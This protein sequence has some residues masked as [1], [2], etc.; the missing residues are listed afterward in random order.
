MVSQD[1]VVQVTAVHR[2]VVGAGLGADQV[3]R[4]LEAGETSLCPLPLECHLHALPDE[5][6]FGYTSAPGFVLDDPQERARQFERH[7]CHAIRVP[8]AATASNTELERRG[9]G[10]IWIA[11]PP[12]AQAWFLRKD[13]LKVAWRDGNEGA[14]FLQGA[15]VMLKVLAFIVH[16]GGV[17]QVK[18][19]LPAH[20]AAGACYQLVLA[21][22]GVG[23]ARA[24]A[25]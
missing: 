9:N 20:L 13:S 23:S 21:W 7:G 16:R 18:A 2:S 17:P 8:P 10:R 24:G 1:S 6:G 11:D 4:Q 25:G 15:Y 19:L 14:L 5:G 22:P 3:G 12:P